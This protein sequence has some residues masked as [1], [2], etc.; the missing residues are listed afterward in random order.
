M[1]ISKGHTGVEASDDT[2]EK[3]EAL[4]AEADMVPDSA[5]SNVKVESPHQAMN[6]TLTRSV[7]AIVNGDEKARKYGDGR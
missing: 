7:A 2:R 3:L 6:Q 1:F 5:S 4:L